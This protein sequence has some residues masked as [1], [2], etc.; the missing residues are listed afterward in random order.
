MPMYRLKREMPTD[1]AEIRLRPGSQQTW[2]RT[3]WIPSS[4]NEWTGLGGS[5]EWEEITEDEARAVIVEMRED[6]DDLP[7]TRTSA[8]AVRVP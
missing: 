5:S 2:T 3:G 1:E 7:Q 4:K 8:Q 6:P